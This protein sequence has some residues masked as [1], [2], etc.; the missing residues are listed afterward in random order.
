M[1][2]NFATMHAEKCMDGGTD[3]DTID[4]AALA[5]D[6]YVLLD[7][8]LLSYTYRDCR[9]ALN[10]TQ[11]PLLNLPAEIRHQIWCFCI[12]NVIINVD[13]ANRPSDYIAHERVWDPAS[14]SLIC[15]PLPRLPYYLTFSTCGPIT[16]N[17]CTHISP[18]NHDWPYPWN[19]CEYAQRISHPLVCKQFW[20][21]THSMFIERA[22][23]VF[24]N[25][26]DL[27]MFLKTKR[28]VAAHVRKLAIHSANWHFRHTLGAWTHHWQQAL[29][30]SKMRHLTR[31]QGVQLHAH[32][33]YGKYTSGRLK[34][35]RHDPLKNNWKLQA[36]LRSLQ[37]HK[38]QASLTRVNLYPLNWDWVDVDRELVEAWT[39]AW[40]DTLLT[41]V[42]LGQG[43]SG[44]E[45][46]W[47]R[48]HLRDVKQ[49]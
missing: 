48:K 21:E 33:P 47:A 25:H 36:I 44:Q 15:K 46:K 13:G 10:A 43:P 7:D 41:H 17:A 23:W 31:L 32:L 37:Q 30:W 19:K 11:S 9:T 38:L 26:Q 49:E 2:K 22:T 16:D 12:R 28:D 34:D 42:P 1:E 3:P 27:A 14:K 35:P 20:F 6:K 40:R 24:F 39:A 4:L 5:I 8:I 29:T 18:R 45:R